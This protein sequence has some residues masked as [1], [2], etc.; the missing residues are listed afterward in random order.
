MRTESGAHVPGAD[1]KEG[2]LMA[3]P[4]AGKK[5]GIIVLSAASER[6]RQ[7]WGVTSCGI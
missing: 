5:L 3:V 1:P 2:E 7:I 6:K 4:A